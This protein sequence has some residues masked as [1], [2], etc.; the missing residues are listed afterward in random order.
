M[1]SLKQIILLSTVLLLISCGSS[2][3]ELNIIGEALPPMFSLEKLSKEYTDST[4]VEISF[5]PYEFETTLQKTQLDFLS[6][7]S[8]YDI[9]MGIFYNHGRYF[10]NNYIKDFSEF[11]TI[12]HLKQFKIPI[13]NFYPKLQDINMKYDDKVIGY[14]FSAQTMFVWYRKDLFENSKERSSFKTQ[15]G[16]DLPVPDEQ[17]L[18]TWKQYYDIAKFFTRNKGEYLAD[19]MLDNN[20]YGTTLQLK[21]HPAS[22]YE[23][24]NFIYSFGGRFFDNENNPQINSDENIEALEYYLSLVQY[25]P[26]GVLQF[27]WDDA[28]TQMQQGKIAMTIMWSDA[29]SALYDKKQSLVVDKIG[30]TLVPIK[31]GVNKKV[32][33][34]GG[35]AFLINSKTEYSEEAYKFIQW[36]SSPNIQL[37]WAKNGGLPASKNIFNDPEYLS[38]PYMKAQNEA[39]KNLVSWPRYPGAEDFISKGIYALSMA[40]TNE[41]TPKESLDWLQNEIDKTR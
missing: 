2:K 36:A 3:V 31:E 41:L 7:N 26:P 29:P 11:D 4:G 1:K 22:F 9:I 27:T 13:D 37:E 17:N 23:F 10:E 16:Y 6:G 8:Q 34:F 33:V 32:S 19:V 18:L 12:P 28:L 24:S 21:R 40:A 25:S 35:W 14:P 5:H 20:F 30:Y 15:Y 39:L 38:I